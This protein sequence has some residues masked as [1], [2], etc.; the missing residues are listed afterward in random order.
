MPVPLPLPLDGG[1]GG[2]GVAA[3]GVEDAAEMR[4]L[5]CSGDIVCVT[6]DT[7]GPVSDC[8]ELGAPTPGAL[9]VVVVVV[10]FEDGGGGGGGVDEVEFEADPVTARLPKSSGGP[11]RR[12]IAGPATTLL[13]LRSTTFPLSG[14]ELFVT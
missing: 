8:V 3:G 7:R 9:V 11:L 6:T 13:R 1:G 2:V 10:P 4:L 5:A 14:V 12:A